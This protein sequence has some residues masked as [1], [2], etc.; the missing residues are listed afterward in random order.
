MS[1][2]DNVSTRT[3]RLDLPFGVSDQILWPLRLRRRRSNQGQHQ[4]AYRQSAHLC[5]S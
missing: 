1:D 5:P 2:N 4:R 3:Q